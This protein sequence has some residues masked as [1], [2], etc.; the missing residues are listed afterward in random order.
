MSFEAFPQFFTMLD[1]FSKKNNRVQNRLA[2][3]I[4]D[5]NCK[6]ADC[7][8][9]AKFESALSD[10]TSLSISSSLISNGSFFFYSL[11]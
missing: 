8:Q 6:I 1:Y 10:L 9:F 5:S 11:N 2:Y 4:L 3:Q 7:N